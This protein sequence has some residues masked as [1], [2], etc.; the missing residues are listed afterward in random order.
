M[1]GLNPGCLL[2]SVL[3]Y[4]L[5]QNI[6]SPLIGMFSNKY[7]YALSFYGFK[8]ILDRPNNF[9]RVPIVLDRSNSFLFGLN[10]FGKL[11][12]ITIRPKSLS[13]T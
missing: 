1:I 9:G 13:L 12:I 11:Q 10:D 2:K 6:L 7:P 3:L 4:T 8:M 5:L